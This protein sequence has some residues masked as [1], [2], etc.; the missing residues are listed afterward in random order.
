MM[1]ISDRWVEV[2]R[3]D[4]RQGIRSC[5]WVSSFE[6]GLFELEKKG[7]SKLAE[8]HKIPMADRVPHFQPPQ[9]GHHA[10]GTAL[11]LVGLE[12]RS[13]PCV[14]RASSPQNKLFRGWLGRHSL[15]TPGP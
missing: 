10:L 3:E 11:G 4:S 5:R 6:V 8:F 14:Q 1:G 7:R 15:E 12:S 2:R 13:E 9:R